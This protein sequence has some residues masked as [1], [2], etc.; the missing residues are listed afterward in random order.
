[1]NAVARE[2]VLGLFAMIA[3]AKLGD[4]V[5]LT[6]YMV[7]EIRECRREQRVRAR[8]VLAATMLGCAAGM[9]MIFASTAVFTHLPRGVAEQYRGLY[10]ALVATG[11]ALSAAATLW[12][13]RFASE[14]WWREWAWAITAAGMVV[15][16]ALE[17]V[18]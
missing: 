17:W 5:C 4:L 8:A 12:R 10:Y 7:L 18:I 2:M 14:A 15:V 13:V 11:A 1:M 9:F 16:A 3:I 6:H